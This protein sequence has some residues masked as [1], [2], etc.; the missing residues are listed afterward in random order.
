M[1][2]YN[3]VLD[4]MQRFT[5][6]NKEFYQYCLSGSTTLDND[7]FTRGFH[8]PFAIEVDDHF[9][10]G[11]DTMLSQILANELVKKHRE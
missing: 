3:E 5:W 8:N 11:Y 2:N 7:Y 1:A 10:T 4:S 9:S 6:Q